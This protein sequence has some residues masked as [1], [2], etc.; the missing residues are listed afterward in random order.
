MFK[1][2]AILGGLISALFI[3]AL[4]AKAADLYVVNTTTANVVSNAVSGGGYLIKAL[5][6]INTTT[7]VSTVKLYDISNTTTTMVQEAYTRLGP[8]YATNITTTFTNAVGIVVTNITAGF[9]TPSAT[10]ASNTI[11]RPYL[12]Q[13]TVPASGTFIYPGAP[14][15]VSQGIA[16]MPNQAGTYQLTY[17]I[18]Q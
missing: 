9:Y 18:E 12:L 13:F 2:L 11:E 7:N 6:W 14:R 16:F 15:A 17:V 3:S 5:T 8:G 1:R 4:P 10:V